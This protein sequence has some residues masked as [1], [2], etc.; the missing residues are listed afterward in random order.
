MRSCQAPVG[1]VRSGRS[2]SGSPKFRG[3]LRLELNVE[4]KR[5]AIHEI[6]VSDDA[7]SIVD[8]AVAQ[9]D[10]SQI[11]YILLRHPC[12]GRGE[13]QRIRHERAR[14]RR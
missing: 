4:S 10:A 2:H 9:P 8:R 6:V 3:A 5:H 11:V 1:A 14:P 12:G 7:R 13:H